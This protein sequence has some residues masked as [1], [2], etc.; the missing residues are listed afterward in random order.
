M[1]GYL[2]ERAWQDSNLRHTVPETVATSLRY[3][4]MPISM[5]FLSYHLRIIS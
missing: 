4:R 2:A 3:Q 5:R 1:V